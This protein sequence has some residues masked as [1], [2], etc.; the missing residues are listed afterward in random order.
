MVGGEKSPPI[1]PNSSVP[2]GSILSPLLF[3]LFINDLPPLIKTNI[4]LFA[5]DLKI[6]VKIRNHQD[7]IALQN[8][9]NLIYEW[10]KWNHLEININKCYVVSYTRRTQITFEYLNYNINNVTLSRQK[11]IKDLGVLFDSELRFDKHANC[12]AKKAY[13]TMGFLFRSLN[14]FKNVETYKLLYF[15]YVRSQLEYCTP[16]WNPYYANHSDTI[17]KVQRRFTKALFRKFRFI[18]EKHYAMRNLRLEILSLKE[19]RSLTDEITLY[20]IYT[21]KL[22]TTLFN[23]INLNNPVRTTRFNNN[24]FYLPTVTTN[25]ECN[26]PMYRFQLQH[27][28]LFRNIDLNEPSFDTFKRYAMHEIKSKQLIFDYSFE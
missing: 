5:D 13:R 7:A 12:I 26:S 8:D 22:K 16:V 1:N 25:V 28:S 27:D 17:E 14:K 3:A 4:L 24:V 21:S 15:T 23:T 9:I 6:F 10:C 19:R 20:K 2:Q 11:L 18:P